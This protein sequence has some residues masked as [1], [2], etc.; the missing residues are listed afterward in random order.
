MQAHGAE[1]GR[2]RRSRSQPRAAAASRQFETERHTDRAPAS[3]CS[4]LAARELNLVPN[5]ARAARY[6]ATPDNRI[7]TYP[8]FDIDPKT[9]YEKVYRP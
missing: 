4:V 5:D 6:I 3:L 7:R 1:R 8:K 2:A 9:Q